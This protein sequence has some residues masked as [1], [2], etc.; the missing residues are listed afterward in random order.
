MNETLTLWTGSVLPEWVDYN[1]HMNDAEY[2][3][4][5]SSALEAFMEHIELGD[6]GR[7]QHQ[8][9]IFT[10]ENHIKYLA[11]AHKGAPLKASILILDRDVKRA[12]L[13]VELKDDSNQLLATSEQMIMGMDNETRRPAPFPPIVEEKLADMPHASF[14]QWPKGANTLIG[15]RRKK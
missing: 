2:A 8:Y 10:L 5:F 12:H 11:E 7:Q 1:G 3:R 6:K 14:D 9:T 4:V 13:W 15:I